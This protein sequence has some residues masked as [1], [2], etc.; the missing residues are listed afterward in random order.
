MIRHCDPSLIGYHGN[1]PCDP[2]LTCSLHVLSLAPP[3]PLHLKQPTDPGSI[4]ILIYRYQCH[5]QI[6]ILSF[7]VFPQKVDIPLQTG[8]S[9]SSS[10]SSSLSHCVLLLCRHM[11]RLC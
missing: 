6:V 3:L 11:T 2:V 8:S 4:Q 10:S 1:R 7:R 9:C 5:Y